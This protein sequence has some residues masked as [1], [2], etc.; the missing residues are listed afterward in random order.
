MV[1][2]VILVIIIPLNPDITQHLPSYGPGV[3]MLGPS[4]VPLLPFPQLAGEC[5]PRPGILVLLG[6]ISHSELA[7]SC[8]NI[9][10]QNK[11]RRNGKELPVQN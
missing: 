1:A 7:R 5:G 8:V 6:R 11:C 4:E 2:V 9:T 10:Q 3:I